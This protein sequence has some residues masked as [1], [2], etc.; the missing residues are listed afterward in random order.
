MGWGGKQE[1]LL[2]GLLERSDVVR[3]KVRE[4][5]KKLGGMGRKRED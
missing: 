3:G 1:Y 4:G 2:T 5:D